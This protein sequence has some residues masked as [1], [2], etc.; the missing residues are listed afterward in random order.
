MR[1]GRLDRTITIQVKSEMQSDSGEPQESWSTVVLLRPASVTPVKGD[2][3]FSG[4]Q[5]VAREQVEFRIRWSED[6][7]TLSP[8]HRV[9]YP[10]LR[11][12][13]DTPQE[14]DIYDVL[15]LHEVGRREGLRIIAQRRADVTS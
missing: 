4:E 1:A 9:I 12:S 8:L 6:M 15:A 11:T 14:R 13:S 10:A 7:S 3:R 2:E 5:I